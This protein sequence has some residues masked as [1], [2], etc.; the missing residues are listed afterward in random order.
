MRKEQETK[1]GELIACHRRLINTNKQEE[2]LGKFFKIATTVGLIGHFF[3]DSRISLV[4][5][6][7]M[8]IAICLQV[9]Q[10]E[11]ADKL[12]WKIR[13]SQAETIEELQDLYE[14]T[15]IFGEDTRCSHNLSDFGYEY[16]NPDYDG[17]QGRN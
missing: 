16:Y 7:S 8:V 11:K 12:S 1:F 17:P 2:N 3:I 15:P 10:A 6:P 4:L 13:K 9:F 14:Q 5:T